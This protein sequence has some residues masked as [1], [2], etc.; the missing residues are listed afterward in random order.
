MTQSNRPNTWS[1]QTELPKQLI[2]YFLVH[3]AILLGLQNKFISLLESLKFFCTTQRVPWFR[4]H[5]N[6]IPSPHRIRSISA[7]DGIC[8]SYLFPGFLYSFS[9]N[10]M[11]TNVASLSSLRFCSVLIS[12]KKHVRSNSTQCLPRED[13]VKHRHHRVQQIKTIP[14]VSPWIETGNSSRTQIVTSSPSKIEKYFLIFQE[15]F[16]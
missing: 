3:R 14:R 9:W 13:I 10:N 2:P 11:K 4:N 12:T 8:Y 16:S 5:P 7:F 6:H 1:C 15:I